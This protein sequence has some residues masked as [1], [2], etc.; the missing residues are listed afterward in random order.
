MHF[1]TLC[2]EKGT[3]NTHDP[4]FEFGVPLT[5]NL[6]P[7]SLVWVNFAVD[8]FVYDSSC[9][10]RFEMYRQSGFNFNTDLRDKI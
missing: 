9:S 10:R 6:P 2:I 7:K 1:Y 3:P 8:R 4:G 5:P